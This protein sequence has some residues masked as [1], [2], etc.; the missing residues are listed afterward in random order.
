MWTCLPA[1]KGCSNSVQPENLICTSIFQ[2]PY[3]HNEPAKY[4]DGIYFLA[5]EL[6]KILP[7]AVLRVFLDA[8][9]IIDAP[10]VR[11]A[12]PRWLEVLKLMSDMQHVQLVQVA[13]PAFINPETHGHYDLFGTIFR[14]IGMFEHE[15]G[16]PI[17]L[18]GGSNITISFESDVTPGFLYYNLNIYKIIIDLKIDLFSITAPCTSVP[19]HIIRESR[20]YPVFAGLIATKFKFP[21][22][23][24]EEFIEIAEDAI[25]NPTNLD[26]LIVQQTEKVRKFDGGKFYEFRKISEQ[27]SPFVYGIDEIFLNFFLIPK[28]VESD[29]PIRHLQL[30][31]NMLLRSVSSKLD[32]IKTGEGFDINNSYIQRFLSIL[33]E[34]IFG[35]S[36]RY[37]TMNEAI[38]IANR[39]YVEI[40][41]NIS[42]SYAIALKYCV[43][44]HVSD[45]KYATIISAVKEAIIAFDNAVPPD[46]FGK[47]FNECWSKVNTLKPYT[48]VV[49]ILGNGKI[50]PDTPTLDE[51][52]LG[53][54]DTL[55]PPEVV[56]IHTN[57]ERKH[58]EE[59]RKKR[60]QSGKSITRR[61]RQKLM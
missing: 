47:F 32:I 17:W 34:A 55:C 13:C 46:N 57:D 42:H 7:N 2:L 9:L 10:G 4:A 50:I 58:I 11:P 36:P 37:L 24:L 19:W 60:S 22:K 33:N 20:L 59:S 49:N 31:M 6:P 56:A 12:S 18:Q 5:K 8:S 52:P 21:A 54:R 27:K 26:N 48:P 1:S 15:E 61:R 28:I 30:V 43:N 38:T 29:R 35:I 41:N 51:M 40:S 44:H 16:T 45:E 23:W 39:I 53:N 25:Q 14:F 3:G